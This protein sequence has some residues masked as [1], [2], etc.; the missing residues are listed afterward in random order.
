MLHVKS[1]YKTK[2]Y[3]IFNNWNKCYTAEMFKLYL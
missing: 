3:N 1:L 2:A